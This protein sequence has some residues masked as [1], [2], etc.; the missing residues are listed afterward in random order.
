[1]IDFKDLL[2]KKKLSKKNIYIIY[3]K[4]KIKKRSFLFYNLFLLLLKVFLADLI[5]IK[6][7]RN[8]IKF[9]SEIFLVIKGKGTQQILFPFILKNQMKYQ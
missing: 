9:Y 1:M 5:T 6:N 7:V 3:K 8:I 2:I 4:R